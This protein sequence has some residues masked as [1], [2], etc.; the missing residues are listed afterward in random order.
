MDRPPPPLLIPLANSTPADPPRLP[1]AAAAA[2]GT[3]SQS[4][5]LYARLFAHPQRYDEILTGH[6][7]D[8]LGQFATAPPW[9]FRRR[10]DSARPDSD[11]Y[12]A[13]YLLL[14]GPDAFGPAAQ[15]VNSWAD[16][17]NSQHLS[18]RVELVTRQPQTGPYG[19]GHALDAAHRVFAADSAAGVAQ[20]RAAGED[21]ATGQAL[22]AAS[23]FDLTV[24]FF[25]DAD[26]AANWLTH[27]LPQER[28]P[29]PRDRT[30][31]TLAL[32]EPSYA[33]V[34]NL[35]GGPDVVAAWHQR[36]AALT[37]YRQQLAPEREPDGV[38][39]SLLHQHYIRALPVDADHERATG[40]LA[41][42]CALRYRER[43]P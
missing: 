20:I 7:P 15:L 28:G 25:G 34:L 12:L 38:L 11:Q 33:T 21:A 31:L 2:P 14:P 22:T 5:V 1:D 17:L 26:R 42:A 37:A 30:A 27:A 6:L 29:L 41:R 10:R 24:Q 18:A 19:D 8:L 43:Q 23:M 3:P 13:L 40:R 36:T 39:R 4:T 35:P 16:N 32:A 9:W